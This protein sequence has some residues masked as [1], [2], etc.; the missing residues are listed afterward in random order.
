MKNLD[1]FGIIMRQTRSWKIVLHFLIAFLILTFVIWR[2]DPKIPTWGDAMWF[3]F[4]VVTTIGFGDYT[5]A[6]VPARIVTALLGI[7]GVFITG[8]VCG[9][10]A[11]WF[12]EKIK[13]PE[14]ESVARMIWQLE[15]LDRLDADALAQVEKRARKS[16][17]TKAEEDS[18]KEIR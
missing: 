8:F 10:G 15:N 7:Y 16:A 9:T 3:G 17:L 11:A 5:V 6:E 18:A 13:K 4:T 14:S 12:Y 2:L 1:L